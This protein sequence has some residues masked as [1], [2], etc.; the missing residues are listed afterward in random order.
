M[1]AL[2]ACCAKLLVIYYK[3]PELAEKLM[4]RFRDL[5]EPGSFVLYLQ[6]F[7]QKPLVNRLEDIDATRAH[8]QRP[9]VHRMLVQDSGAIVQATSDSN[10]SPQMSIINS[11][12]YSA[13]QTRSTSGK[14]ELILFD[15]NLDKSSRDGES[16]TFLQNEQ[17]KSMQDKNNNLTVQRC[18]KTSKQDSNQPVS[19]E[20]DD[21]CRK[22]GAESSEKEFFFGCSKKQF[23]QMQRLFMQNIKLNDKQRE[24]FALILTQACWKKIGK[25]AYLMQSNLYKLIQF[26]QTFFLLKIFVFIYCNDCNIMYIA[27]IKILFLDFLF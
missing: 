6:P 2:N 7:I 22:N 16:E 10:S 15:G 8:I 1:V 27:I 13:Q 12:S 25:K 4:V 3:S 24:Q 23:A 17:R 11:S 9:F 26:C 19:T 21:R 18:L 14:R 20:K 5:Q